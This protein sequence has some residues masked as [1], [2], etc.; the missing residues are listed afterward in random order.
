MIIDTRFDFRTDSKGKDPDSHSCTLREYQRCLYSKP[1]PNGEIME[2][3]EKLNWKDFWF[4]SDSILHG[5][6]G[7]ESYKHITSNADQQLIEKYVKSDYFISG[8]IIFPCYRVA[9][10]QTINQARGCNKKICDRIDLT[11]ECIRRFYTG[12][13]SPLSKCLSG[14]KSFFDLFVDFKGYT[15]FFFMQDMVSEDYSSIKFLTWFDDFVSTFPL[16]RSVQEYNDYLVKVIEFNE[17]RNKRIADW[18][19]SQ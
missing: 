11:M 7:W 10:T 4:S 13:T 16:P 1:L 2:L 9:G 18:C 6:I 12:E 3:S 17:L 19:Q 5:F 15:D 8:E 14:Y